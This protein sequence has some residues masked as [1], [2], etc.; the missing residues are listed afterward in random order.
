M[1]IKSRS[2]IITAVLLTLIVIFAAILSWQM[3]KPGDED[4]A[5]EN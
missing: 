4:G 5:Y 1:V 3:L 2:K